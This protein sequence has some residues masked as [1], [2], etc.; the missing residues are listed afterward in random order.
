MC[1]QLV[2]NTYMIVLVYSGAFNPVHEGHIKLLTTIKD[3]MEKDSKYKVLRAFMS[4]SSNQYVSQKLGSDAL[5]LEHRCETCRIACHDYDW[6]QVCNYGLPSG[7][8]T[9]Q[10]LIHDGLIPK[11]TRV[12][13]VGGID[14]VL[15][16]NQ[17]RYNKQFICVGRKGYTAKMRTQGNFI[18][19]NKELENISS[20]E[21]RNYIKN[22][23]FI[24]PVSKGWMNPTV[25]EYIKSNGE[26][27]YL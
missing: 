21:I 22:A 18:F 27:L 16:C 25:M 20:T 7:Y 24:T 14:F 8:R 9:T 3:E 2:I 26:S 19:I 5:T 1:R 6:I 11:N 15:R 4:P 12:Y 23:D 13:E 10:Q 17:L